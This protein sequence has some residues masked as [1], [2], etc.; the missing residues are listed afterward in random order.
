MSMIGKTLGHYEIVKKIGSGGMGVVYK[1]R[2]LHLDR[3]VALKVLPSEK[4]AD[5]ERKRR[6]VQEAKA[7]S[8]L[9]HPNIIHIY[10]IT[11]D[12]GV[13]FIAMEYVEGKTLDER[14]GHRGLSSKDT[15]KYAVQIADALAK[16]H[17]AGI[18]HRDLKPSNIMVNEDDTV[19]ILD[20][21]LA[22]LTEQVKAGEFASTATLEAGEKPVTEK[23]VIVGTV[24]YL[25]PEQ[26]EGKGVDSRSDIFSFGSVLYEMITGRRAFQADSKISTI[27]A[28]LNKEPAPL[29]PD[30]PHDLEKAIMR[31]LRKDPARRWQTMSDLKVALQDLKEDSESGKLSTAASVVSRRKRSTWLF[32]MGALILVVAAAAVAWQLFHKPAPPSFETERLTFGSGLVATPAISQD[33]KMLVYSSDHEGPLNLYLQQLKGRTS[34][35]LTNQEASDLFPDFSPDGSKIVFC[36]ARDGGGIYEIDALG[37]GERRIVDRG[38]FPRFSPDGSTI[39][40]VVTPALVTM[41]KMYLIGAKAGT[42][43]RFQPDFNVTP[44]GPRCSSPPVWSPDGKYILFDGSREGDPKSRDWWIA[45]VAGGN[46]TRVMAPAFAGQSVIRITVAWRGKYVYWSEGTTIGGM[47]IYRAPIS[48]P[49]WKVTGVPERITSPLGMQLASSISADGRLAFSSWTPSINLWSWPP[50]ANE[51]AASGERRQITFDSDVK[52]S[53]DVAANG[54]RLVYAAAT[55]PAQGSDVHLRAIPSGHDE[56][57]ASSNALASMPRLSA[58]GSRVAWSDLAEG[59]PVAYLS[60]PGAA[61]PRQICENC[62][63]HDFFSS[64]TEALIAYGSQLVRQNLATGARTPLL[65]STGFVLADAALSP[66]GHWMAFVVFRP[67]GMAALYVAPAGNQTVPRNAWVQIAED[68]YR[69]SRPS[70]SPDGKLIYYESSRDDHYCLWAQRITA[71][72]QP[73]GVPVGILHLHQSF[74]PWIYGGASFGVTSDRL[75]IL[76]PEV[77]GNAYMVKV[78]R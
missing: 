5:P 76:L 44:C 29:S 70:W 18:V 40:Y 9:N 33:G 72:G 38:W 65:D 13:D 1:A 68:R 43:R 59:K 20:F 46:P 12:T 16:A 21:G 32:S 56:V 51:T 17:S 25:S 4:V 7:A 60:E 63:V 36:S 53:L 74:H 8:A 28:V 6:F 47:S 61:S 66:G 64:S 73:D 75:Y 67:D 45:P 57:I 26:A 35:R 78:D 77:K 19:K 30:I 52:S 15:L 11:S 58:D 69:L 24:A 23:G 41:G 37:G 31:C 27:S 2:D 48:G 39:A 14:I 62:L 71:G 3:F 34:I 22:K 54:S 50:R 55:R 10:D 49:S 42:P